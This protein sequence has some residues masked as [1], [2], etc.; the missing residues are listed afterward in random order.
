MYSGS[1]SYEFGRRAGRP[2]QRERSE[3]IEAGVERARNYRRMGRLGGFQK[4]PELHRLLKLRDGIK[5]FDRR[6]ESIR[7]APQ[8][9]RLKFS[10]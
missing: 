3:T 6:G 9:S 4:G 7:E 5:F 1:V 10:C 2:P 8:R